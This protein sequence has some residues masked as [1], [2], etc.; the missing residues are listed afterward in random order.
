MAGLSSNDIVCSQNAV[1]PYT[2]SRFLTKGG[3]VLWISLALIVLRAQDLGIRLY[4][5][6]ER[7]LLDSLSLSLCLSYSYPS[8]L[9]D[10]LRDS[11]SEKLGINMSHNIP[12]T[13]QAR[14]ARRRAVPV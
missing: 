10:F 7:S 13:T 8:I 12:F 6:A 5:Q 1:I 9:V 4:S 14:F 2:K 3:K 11:V